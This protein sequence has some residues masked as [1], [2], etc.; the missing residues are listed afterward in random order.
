MSDCCEQLRAELAAIKAE[1]AGLNGRF[2]RR[3]ERQNIIDDAIGGAEAL[4]VP[5]F[6]AIAASKVVPIESG[7]RALNNRVAPFPGQ[8]RVLQ[9]GL[10]S[11]TAAADQANRLAREGISAAG[12]ANSAAQSAKS[13]ALQALGR[14]ASLALTVANLAGTVAALAGL[15]VLWG[16]VAV[17]ERAMSSVQQTIDRI[18]GQILPG[19]SHQLCEKAVCC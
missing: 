15:F 3:N 6:G 14:I 7:L 5:M 18:L 11:A 13:Q 10:A 16:K 9:G 2:I 19:M 4:L 17:L 8:I 1:I 12:M